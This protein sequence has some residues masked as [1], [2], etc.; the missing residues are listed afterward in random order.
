MVAKQWFFISSAL[1]WWFCSEKRK[2]SVIFPTFWP[3]IWGTFCMDTLYKYHSKGMPL[4]WTLLMSIIFIEFGSKVH[5]LL[6]ALSRWIFS[7]SWHCTKAKNTLI[8]Y[9]INL[10]GEIVVPR[11]GLRKQGL[12]HAAQLHRVGVQKPSS[13]QDAQGVSVLISVP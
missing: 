7:F 13:S 12:I 2:F 6:W 11:P 8:M 9:V 3:K 1:F 4:W 10:T 5:V